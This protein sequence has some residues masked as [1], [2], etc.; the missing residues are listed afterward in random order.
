MQQLTNCYQKDLKKYFYR[1]IQL[2]AS[3]LSYSIWDLLPQSGVKLGPP[4][5]GAH[6][7]S[8]WTIRKSLKSPPFFFGST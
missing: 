3:G 2:S 5:L 4:A 8:Y 7:P 1:F 6:S